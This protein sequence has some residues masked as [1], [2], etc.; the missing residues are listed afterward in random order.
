MPIAYRP[1]LDGLGPTFRISELRSRWDELKARLA[2][3]EHLGL[4][5]YTHFI[6][7]LVP[8]DDWVRFRDVL[9]IG[10]IPPLSPQLRAALLE[11]GLDPDLVEQNR[12]ALRAHAT[13]FNADRIAELQAEPAE[14]VSASSAEAASAAPDTSAE[15]VAGDT[16]E[17]TASPVSVD[18]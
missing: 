18:A 16:A 15:P 3:G 8:A 12:L 6:G 4:A 13:L 7:V 11:E 14:E 5:R 9:G 17:T 2:A 1:S 10:T